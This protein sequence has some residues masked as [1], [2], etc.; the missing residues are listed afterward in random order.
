MLKQYFY[1][2]FFNQLLYNISERMLQKLKENWT[3]FLA[4][5]NEDLQLLI[6]LNQ[7]FSWTNSNS[8]LKRHQEP[9]RKF[10]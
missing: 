7:L 5:L 2:T 4:S 3:D 10:T 8:V 1:N 9:K 6:V